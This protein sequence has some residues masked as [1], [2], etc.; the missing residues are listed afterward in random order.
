MQTTMH[1]ATYVCRDNG[2]HNA[3]SPVRSECQPSTLSGLVDVR[4][5]PRYR[6]DITPENG[7]VSGYGVLGSICEKN[8][9]GIQNIS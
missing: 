2:V 1:I 7:L 9:F 3:P 6:F 4:G 8:N 5:W